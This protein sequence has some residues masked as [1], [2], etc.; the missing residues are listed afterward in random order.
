MM[1]KFFVVFVLLI[2]TALFLC[3][4]VICKAR[5]SDSKAQRVF[6]TRNVILNTYDTLIDGHHLHYAITGDKN[7]PSLVFIHGS[8]GSWFHYMKFMCAEEIPDNNY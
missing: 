6:K 4:C 5:W 3:R 2:F 7:L 8:P 1:K